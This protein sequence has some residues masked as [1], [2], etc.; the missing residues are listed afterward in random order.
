MFECR[1]GARGRAVVVAAL[2]VVLLGIGLPAMAAESKSTPDWFLRTVDGKEVQFHAALDRGPVL[3]SFWALWCAPC[4]KELPHIDALAKEFGEQ[5]TVLAV[6][7]DTQR[8][9][10]RVRPYLRSKG[11]RVTVPL[12]TAGELTRKL[13]VGNS[14][15]FTVLYDRTGKAVYRH[16]GY[17]D[18]DEQKLRAEVEALLAEEANRGAQP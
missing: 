8:S 4:L 17:R 13:Q 14:I 12:D 6:N 3:V 18:G 5:L 1:L 10:S 9:V 2:A 15:P 16:L 7:T 11:Y